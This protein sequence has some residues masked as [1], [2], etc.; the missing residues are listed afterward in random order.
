M[1]DTKITALHWRRVI[2]VLEDRLGKTP[3]SAEI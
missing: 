3:Y 1:T 2:E